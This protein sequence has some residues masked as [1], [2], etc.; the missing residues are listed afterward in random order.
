MGGKG[1]GGGGV[2]TDEERRAKQR[3]YSMTPRNKAMRKA[4]NASDIGKAKRRERDSR[5]EVKARRKAERDRPEVKARRKERDSRPD[6]IAN[7]LKNQKRIRATPEY[8][9]RES[10]RNLMLR[11]EILS[12][13]SKRMSNSD[14]PMC[15]CC[16]LN[17]HIDFLELDHIQ[18]RELMNSIKELTDIG[19]PAKKSGAVLWNWLKKHNYLEHLDTDYFQVLCKNCNQAKGMKKNNNTSPHKLMVLK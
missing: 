6:V 17:D 2:Q 19:Y 18:G 12:N 8:K 16:G 13:L 15:A 11:V 9:I 4:Y 1:S 10:K 14:K 3:V 5:P 7:R